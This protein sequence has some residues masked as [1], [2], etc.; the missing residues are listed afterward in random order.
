ME[1]G[2]TLKKVIIFLAVV[3]VLFAAIFFITKYQQNQKAKNNPYGKADLHP[4][5]VDQLDDPNYQNIILPNEL[6]KKLDHKE[7][8]VVYFY[9]PICPHC[10]KTT[11]ILMSLAKNMKVHIYQYNLL[12]FEQGWDDYHIQYTPTLVYFENGKEKAR[13]VGEQ[14][15]EKFQSFLKEAA[16]K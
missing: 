14:P 6:K 2:S 4:E 9:S 3:I 7:S 12:E 8:L 1:G 16:K 11:P 15:K 10:K 5:T 13:L